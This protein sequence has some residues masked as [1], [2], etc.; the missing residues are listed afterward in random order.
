MQHEIPKKNQFK[1]SPN[2]IS[3]VMIQL[4]LNPP[5]TQLVTFQLSKD[6]KICNS[7]LKKS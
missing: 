4:I 2:A 1:T 7:S 6:E 5:T 3:I